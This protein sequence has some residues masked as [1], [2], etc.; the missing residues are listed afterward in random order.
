MLLVFALAVALNAAPRSVSTESQSK[1]T[2]PSE[3]YAYVRQPMEEWEAAVHAG[4]RPKTRMAPMEEVHRHA[5]TWCPNFDVEKQS[6]EELYFLALLCREALNWQKSKIAVQ[7]Y[8]AGSQQAH[9]PEARLLLA[10][11]EISI[12]GLDA[13]WQTLRT[14]LERDP[15]GSEQEI[16][17]RSVI[18][19]ESNTS[20]EK[21]LE[22]ARER[23]LLLLGRAQNEAPGVP[24]VS[25][26]WV[27]MAGADLV[28][29]YWLFGKTDQAQEILA[30]LNHIKDFHLKEVQGWASEEL[31]WANMEMQPAPSIPVLKLLGTESSS[32]MIQKGRVEVVSFFFLGCGPC[33]QEFATLN[34]LQK[35]YR[36]EKLLVAD[37]TTYKANSYMDPPTHT[38][39]EAALNRAWRKKAPYLTMVVTS[40]GTLANYQVVAFPVVVVI[41]KAGRVRYV[42]REIDFEDDEPLGRLIR[43]LLEE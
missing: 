30:E 12:S 27:V 11:S 37:V 39:I 23:Y 28:H 3:A 2:K 19:D 22:W 40:D 29:R 16:M 41:D 42:G 20:E 33:I 21:A 10:G 31:H 6:G 14:V 34:N 9:G 18:D 24:I 35:R 5:K 32:E 26:Q 17:T 36:N 8:L 4:Q 13:S 1:F 15:I 43:S 25:F 7:Q 38:T